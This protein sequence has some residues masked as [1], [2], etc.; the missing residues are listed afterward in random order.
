MAF[1]L[2]I[3][4]TAQSVVVNPHTIAA[5]GEGGALFGLTAGLYGA[6]TRKDIADENAALI[7]EHVGTV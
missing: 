3:S 7:G 6:I 5:Q 1:T 4:E 2:K